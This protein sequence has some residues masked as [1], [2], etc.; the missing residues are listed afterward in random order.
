MGRQDGIAE[1]ADI[2]QAVVVEHRLSE[3]R[4]TVVGFGEEKEV[5]ERRLTDLGLRAR[6][7]F[8]GR[9]DHARVLEIIGDADVCIDPAPCNDLNHRTT[10]VKVVEYLSLGRP[11]VAYAL[12]ET[13]RT[14][15]DAAMLAPCGDRTRFAAAIAALARSQEL[16]DEYSAR[17]RARA[18]ELAWERSEESLLAGYARMFT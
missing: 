4:M 13:C 9:T 10:M 3:A 1:L 5:L 6:V 8:T 16:R 12:L 14:A 15:G 7:T 17:A 2:L 11:T 18:P